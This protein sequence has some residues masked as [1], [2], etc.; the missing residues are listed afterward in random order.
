MYRMWHKDDVF[1]ILAVGNWV[2]FRKPCCA[3]TC[4]SVCS[5]VVID[6][7]MANHNIIAATACLETKL[8]AHKN[9]CFLGMSFTFT[10]VAELL[11]VMSIQSGFAILMI[12]SL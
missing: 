10:K 12:L 6:S 2:E 5:S 1:H 11:R 9:I 8:T 3:R 4:V 7:W